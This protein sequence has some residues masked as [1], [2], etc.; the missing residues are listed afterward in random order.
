[1]PNYNW[2]K[3]ILEQAKELRLNHPNFM[4]E[5]F[6]KEGKLSILFYDIFRSLG[7]HFLPI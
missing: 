1:L 3:H 5:V 4:T 6:E 2:L 7:T